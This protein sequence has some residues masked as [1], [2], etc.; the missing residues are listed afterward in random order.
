MITEQDIKKKVK[1]ALV[2]MW[3]DV[4]FKCLECFFP[5]TAATANHS[6]NKNATYIFMKGNNKQ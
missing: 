1:A 6:K 3:N 4:K 2:S 5:P